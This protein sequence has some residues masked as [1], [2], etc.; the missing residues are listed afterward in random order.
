M[1]T[2]K[3]ITKINA[4][5]N[6]VFDLNRNIDI[7]KLSTSK[8]KETAI[9]GITFGLINLYETVTWRGKHF[10]IYLTHKSLISAMEIPNYFV[11]EMIEGRFKSFKHEHAFVEKDG[12]TVMID[13]IEY[14]TPFG[15]F[16][17]V[18]DKIILKK[19]LKSFITER[20]QF[21]KNLAENQQ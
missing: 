1:T 16:G 14:K 4:P 18:F 2:I 13:S 19:H 3:L 9:D 15:I 7:H 10:G 21:I 20:N 5:I 11:D 6:K 12:K 17:Q 8:S